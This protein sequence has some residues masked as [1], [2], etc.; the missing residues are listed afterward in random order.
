MTDSPAVNLAQGMGIG[1]ARLMAGTLAAAAP[2]TVH[3]FDIHYRRDQDLKDRVH[4]GD[5]PAAIAELFGRVCRALA[6]ESVAPTAKP[7]GTSSDVDRR[8]RSACLDRAMS[9][10][11]KGEHRANDVVSAAEQ[12]ARFVIDGTQPAD[13]A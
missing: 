5:G 3:L 10:A 11:P 6:A 1:D 9:L 13:A 8:T 4:A 2:L 7:V 12:L